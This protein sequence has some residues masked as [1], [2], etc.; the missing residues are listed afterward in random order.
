MSKVVFSETGYSILGLSE[1]GRL[2]ERVMTLAEWDIE[3]AESRILLEI[4][5]P[6]VWAAL[7]SDARTLATQTEDD[8]IRVWDTASA[9]C[10]RLLK[11]SAASCGVLRMMDTHSLA[12]ARGI[13]T[14]FVCSQ[15]GEARAW[16]PES[17]RVK[18]DTDGTSWVGF[19]G[20]RL[21][22]LRLERGVGH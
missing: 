6:L 12:L 5:E 20:N 4:N 19:A 8:I 13:E 22:I 21:C 2:G 14:A 3:T 9:Q 16:F 18:P 1:D 11:G 7:S 17:V 10:V 15:T